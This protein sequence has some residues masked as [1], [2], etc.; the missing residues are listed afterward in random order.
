[1]APSVRERNNTLVWFTKHL[2]KLLL[3]PFFRIK[4]EGLRNVSKNKSFILTPKHQRWEDIPLLSISTPRPLYYIAKNELFLNPFTGW[5]LSSLGGLPLNRARPLESRASFKVMMERLGEGEG[6]VIFPEGTYFKDR[7]GPGRIG[8]VKMI[9]SR[10]KVP[11]IPVGI[12]YAKEG[13]Q[14]LV[15][16]HFGEALYDDPSETTESFLDRIMNEIK[17]LSRF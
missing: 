9:R 7:V 4:T 6:L 13:R 1:M 10:I 2:S 14:T 3:S 16:M 12:D 5:F 11:F 17:R 8:M 15:R